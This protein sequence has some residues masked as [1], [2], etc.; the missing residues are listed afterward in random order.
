MQQLAR[1]IVPWQHSRGPVF[2]HVPPGSEWAWPGLQKESVVWG[3]GG[4][5]GWLREIPVWRGHANGPALMASQQT[6]GHVLTEMGFG[7]DVDVDV[8]G[9]QEGHWQTAHLK[10]R[11]MSAAS[12]HVVFVARWKIRT[13]SLGL[14]AGPHYPISSEVTHWGRLSLLLLPP[15][16]LSLVC[17]CCTFT[18]FLPLYS[19]DSQCCLHHSIIFQHLTF[20][21]VFS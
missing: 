10:W 7:V 16:S 21:A 20:I 18:F 4:H 19:I 9:R 1:F 11:Q 3:W 12:C 2:C 14:L 17:S 13:A 5:R 8:E 6:V 15:A